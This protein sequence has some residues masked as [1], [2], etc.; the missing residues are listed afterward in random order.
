MFKQVNSV[1]R[2]RLCDINKSPSQ[3][4]NLYICYFVLFYVF[5]LVLFK[6]NC[7]ANEVEVE[8][9]LQNNRIELAHSFRW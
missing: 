9:R 2:G 4:S 8:E 1:C 5:V 7:L 6:I 3:P